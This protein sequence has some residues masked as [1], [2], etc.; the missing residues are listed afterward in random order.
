MYLHVFMMKHPVL[1]SLLLLKRLYWQVMAIMY[2]VSLK[3]C[4]LK[5]DTE[6][7]TDKI[8]GFI[9]YDPAYLK[10]TGL[11]TAEGGKVTMEAGKIYQITDLEFTEEHLT[12][13]DPGEPTIC[14]TATVTVKDWEIVP[15]EPEYGK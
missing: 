15:V 8:E 9:V 4:I 1:K 10:I 11:K 14:V 6:Y 13:L 7:K 5:F 12:D 2:W 3:K